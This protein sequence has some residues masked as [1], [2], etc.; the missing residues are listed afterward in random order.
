[1]TNNQLIDYWNNRTIYPKFQ[2][3]PS[4]NFDKASIVTHCGN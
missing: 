3:A 4:E 2:T 1:V